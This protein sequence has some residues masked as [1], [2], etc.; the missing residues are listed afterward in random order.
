MTLQRK[1]EIGLAVVTALYSLLVFLSHTLFLQSQTEW[2]T[3]QTVTMA[4]L[5]LMWV[6][7]YASTFAFLASRGV[8]FAA[9]IITFPTILVF[10][11]GGYGVPAIATAGVLGALM[12]SAR[13]SITLESKERVKIR[14]PNVFRHGARMLLFG[15]L[16][17]LIVIAL[18]HVQRGVVSGQI[19]VAS[20]V[21]RAVLA[22]ATPVLAQLLPGYTA[23]A[24]VDQL[25][26]QYIAQQQSQLPAGFA[27][28]QS[29]KVQARVELGESLGLRIQGNETLSELLAQY[30]NQY[31]REAFQQV[32]NA[33]TNG[34]FLILATGLLLA[35]LALRAAAGVLVWPIFALIAALIYL[36]ER[37]GLVIRAKTQ[38]TVEQLHL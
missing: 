14:I 21:I 10:V 28:P 22:P 1:K 20:P 4:L 37:I 16:I 18:P 19:E 11:L 15:L 35:I 7:M 5:G 26:D 6:A 24:T 2:G 17:S 23:E 12:V 29:Q 38:V 9:L 8:P 3:A 13:R 27:V 25:I 36:S 32:S 30:V 34:K 31:L 33:T